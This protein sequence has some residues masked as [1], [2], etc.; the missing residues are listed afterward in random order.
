MHTHTHTYAH[1]FCT[2][3]QQLTV[4][5]F[6][7][8]FWLPTLLSMPSLVPDFWKQETEPG[9]EARPSLCLC[10]FVYEPHMTHVS[11]PLR[12]LR[13]N[14][15][16]DFGMLETAAERLRQWP[17]LVLFPPRFELCVTLITLKRGTISCSRTLAA[18]YDFNCSIKGLRG[19]GM[20]CHLCVWV[21]VCVCE[22][23]CVCLM[24]TSSGSS[25]LEFIL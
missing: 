5:S 20:L 7:G 19:L 10:A 15:R 1:L 24:L 22:S 4:Y 11:P 8:D 14:I 25:A 16:V 17:S 3:Q 9:T 18:F 2:G 23:V 6:N 21:C 13:R 12:C